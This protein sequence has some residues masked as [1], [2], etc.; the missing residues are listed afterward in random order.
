MECGRQDL[1]DKL[2]SLYESHRLCGA[3]FETAMFLNDLKNRLQ[4]HAIPRL[5]QEQEGSSRD[6]EHNYGSVPLF[7]VEDIHLTG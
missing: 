6:S 4:P 3:H 7:S 1:L 2:E 5:F